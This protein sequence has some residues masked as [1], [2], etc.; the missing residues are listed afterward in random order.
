MFQVPTYLCPGNHDG[1]V[2]CGQDGF[3]LWKKYFGPLY[4]SFDYG[5]YHFTS[6]NSYDWPKLGRFAISLAAFNWGG[7]IQEEQLKWIEE[8]LENNKAKLN[9]MNLHHN[10]L[11]DTK[12][13]SL[14]RKFNYRGREKLLSLIVEYDVDAVFAGHVH[15][16]NITVQ[17]N[18]IYI[19]T[20]TVTSNHREDSYWGY[21]LI[22]IQNSQV[23]S[24]NY[25]EP[26]YSI[27]SYKLN[28]TYIHSNIAIVEN[29]LEKDITAYLKFI[30]PIKSYNIENGD[31]I[32]ERQVEDFVEIYVAAEV[33]KESKI[34]IT[35]S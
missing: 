2:Q 16:D 22:E 21:R 20:T 5:D 18:T 10:P 27:P 11:W 25:K 8:D 32:L 28:Y 7:C 23:E 13:E 30:L 19:T 12:N 26:H 15:Y 31:I 24:Y 14:I 35:L 6:V 17:N 4:Y 29:D 9:F 33:E 3:K 1:Y 34:T